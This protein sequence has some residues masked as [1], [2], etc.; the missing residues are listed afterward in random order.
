MTGPHSVVSYEEL[1]EAVG[2][3]AYAI[4]D[5]REPH[6]F[7]EGH[8]PGAVNLPMSRFDPSLL[9]SGKPVVLIC[10]SGGRSATALQRALASGLSDIR[11]YAGGTAGWQ[12]RGGRVEK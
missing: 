2:S 1:E 8:V 11:H 4:V 5:V 6:E 12:G 3:D 10:K 7:S 9:P